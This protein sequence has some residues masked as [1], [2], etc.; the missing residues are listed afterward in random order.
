MDAFSFE[1]GSEEMIPGR[2]SH[3]KRMAGRRARRTF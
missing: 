1:L 3:M 2:D